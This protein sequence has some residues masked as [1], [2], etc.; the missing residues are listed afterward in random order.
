[1]AQWLGAQAV[2][3]EDSRLIPSTH[4][5]VHNSYNS[6]PIGSTA[7]F[8]SPQAQRQS[9][10]QQE[11]TNKTSKQAQPKQTTGQAVLQLTLAHALVTERSWDLQL[12]GPSALV[13]P[14]LGSQL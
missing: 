6:S 1:M 11:H 8:W 4:M 3:P 10:R 9:C 13:S 2:L 14:V 5:T 7:L 12:L